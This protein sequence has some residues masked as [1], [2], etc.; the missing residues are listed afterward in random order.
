MRLTRCLPLAAFILAALPFAV[1]P[2][3]A[4]QG[5][6]PGGPGGPGG[7]PGARF[8]RMIQKLG[9]DATQQQK[10]QA[11]LDAAKPQRE[12]IRGRIHQAFQDMHTLLDQDSPDQNKVLAQAEVIGQITT[13]AHKDMLM[14][15]LAVRAELRPDQLAKLKAMHDQRGGPGRWHRRFRGGAP[16]SPPTGAPDGSTDSAPGT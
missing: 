1:S 5:G 3:R 14:T 10:V 4:D 13:E 16:G 11:I 8:E 7:E 12:E 9:L 2:A 6:G 15:L